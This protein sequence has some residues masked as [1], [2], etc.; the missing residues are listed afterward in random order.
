MRPLSHYLEKKSNTPILLLSEENI[1]DDVS[2]DILKEVS[3][4]IYLYSETATFTANRIYT[5]IHRY[6]ESLL[7]LFLKH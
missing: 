1:T 2:I 3:E 5:L 7:P 6:A 4:Y